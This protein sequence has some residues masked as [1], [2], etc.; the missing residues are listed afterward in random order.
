MLIAKQISNG[1]KNLEVG[2]VSLPIKL[3]NSYIIVKINNKKEF[4]Q[5]LNL[6][7]QLERVINQETNRQ[8][9]NFSIIF[10]KRLKKNIEI[11]EY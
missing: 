1:I 7:D 11:N 3:Q 2:Q 4:K 9:N 10:Y 6:E 8:L 5:Q